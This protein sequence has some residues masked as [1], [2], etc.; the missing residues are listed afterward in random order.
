MRV[1][2]T[3][4]AVTTTTHIHTVVDHMDALYGQWMDLDL[5][6]GPVPPLIPH[7]Y[8]RRSHTHTHTYTYT[9]IHTHIH[10]HIHIHTYIHTHTYMQCP[11]ITLTRPPCRRIH[12]CTA[13]TH[14]THTHIHTHTHTYTYTHIY[15]H[16]HTH[17][18][19][20]SVWR[21]LTAIRCA[22]TLCPCAKFVNARA[23]YEEQ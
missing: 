12:T 13:H 8:P 11:N 23:A 6:V 7:P 15:T 4:N 16:T 5:Q 17:M 9:H 10:I 2:P 1:A 21:S 19:C 20:P 14:T 18:H 3:P 22:F